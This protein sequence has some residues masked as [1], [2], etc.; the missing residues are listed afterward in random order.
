METKVSASPFKDALDLLKHDHDMVKAK[1][2]EFDQLGEKALVSKKKLADEICFELKNHTTLEEELFY[3]AIR[4]VKGLA[5]LVD[6]AT[7]EHGSAKK[8]I[9]DIQAMEPADSL[10]DAKVKVLSE[11]IAHHVEEEEQ[12]IFPQLKSS[13]IDLVAL[14]DKMMV[15]KKHLSTQVP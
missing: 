3:P 5:S 4:R 1:F 7:V 2:E 9:D 6:E 10:F 15:R 12:E 8:L 13:P 14:R 11:Q